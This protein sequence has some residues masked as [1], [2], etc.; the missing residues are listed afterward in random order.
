MLQEEDT[1]KYLIA[2]QF[3]NDKISKRQLVISWQVINEVTCNLI[4]YKFPEKQ[5]AVIIEWIC[6]IAY[7]EN[8]TEEL[9]IQAS[10]FREKF[11]FSFWDSLI[12]SAALTSHCKYLISEDMQNGQKIDGMTIEN[13]FV[14]LS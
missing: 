5:I 7:I 12:V 3:I 13:I 10:A 4:R 14:A 1:N 9:L 2:K 8:F 11:P 6:K